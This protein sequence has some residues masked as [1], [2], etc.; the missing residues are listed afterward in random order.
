MSLSSLTMK[1]LNLIRLLFLRDL[2][3]VGVLVDFLSI[4]I[5]PLGGRVAPIRQ[6]FD[7]EFAILM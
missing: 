4:T 5:A 2:N 3:F 6:T 1:N 7:L